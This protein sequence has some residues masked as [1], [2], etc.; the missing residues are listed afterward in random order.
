MYSKRNV[1]EMAEYR[2]RQA[3]NTRVHGLKSQKSWIPYQRRATVARIPASTA[4]LSSNYRGNGASL[5]VDPTPAS[6]CRLALIQ[7]PRRQLPRWYTCGRFIASTVIRVRRSPL[8]LS[9]GRVRSVSLSPWTSLHDSRSAF[10]AASRLSGFNGKTKNR[11]TFVRFCLGR[12]LEK[13]PRANEHFF[14]RKARIQKRRR[15]ITRHL[16]NDRV[17]SVRGY[18]SHLASF[19]I[20]RKRKLTNERCKLWIRPLNKVPSNRYLYSPPFASYFCFLVTLKVSSKATEY[21]FS[22][23]CLSSYL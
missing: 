21:G 3:T 18:V 13:E 12:T 5:G 17:R 9:L 8:S 1:F 16:P 7:L 10:Q 23:H 20:E 11:R 2:R 6:I 14:K 4:P 22:F 15:L 19:E